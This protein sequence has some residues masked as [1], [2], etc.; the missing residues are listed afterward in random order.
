MKTKLIISLLLTLLTTPKLL[1]S[2]I[3]AFDQPPFVWGPGYNQTLGF[4]FDVTSPIKIDGL[5]YFDAGKNGLFGM[6]DLGL[7][8]INRNLLAAITIPAGT[9]APLDN[10]FRWKP[11]QTALTLSRG[12]YVVAGFTHSATDLYAG[13]M[14]WPDLTAS[15][16][17]TYVGSMHNGSSSGLTYPNG[18]P[19]G[20]P[21]SPP[22]GWFG[23]NVHIA[24][25]PEP[26]TWVAGCAAL[27]VVVGPMLRR[28]H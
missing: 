2:M 24:P 4:A 5:G 15:T 21:Y 14:S 9:T 25:V 1:A 7:W 16:G 13:G 6:V 23:G 8:D 17:I 22:Q 19:Q 18:G 10:W 11:I 12:R 26:S 20:G 3:V 27:L 28:K